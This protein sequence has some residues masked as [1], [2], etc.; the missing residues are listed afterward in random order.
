MF[1]SIDDLSLLVMFSLESQIHRGYAEELGAKKCDVG[2]RFIIL[3]VVL[4]NA[5][6][7]SHVQHPA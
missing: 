7:G 1:P 6:K 3:G 2:T 4:G 5:L